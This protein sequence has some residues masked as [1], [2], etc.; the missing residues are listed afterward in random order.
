LD[1]LAASDAK[2]AALFEELFRYAPL[3]TTWHEHGIGRKS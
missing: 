2:T 1:K 3:A